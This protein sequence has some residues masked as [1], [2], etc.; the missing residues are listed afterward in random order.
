MAR[1]VRLPIKRAAAAALMLAA[2]LAAPFTAQAALPPDL[3]ERLARDYAR[4]AVAKMTDA[5]AALEGALGE[6][7]A[8]LREALLDIGAQMR[9]VGLAAVARAVFEIDA[10]LP[11]ELA[12]QRVELSAAGAIGEDRAGHGDVPF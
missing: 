8:S 11:E 9:A 3:G 10:C 5:A 6:E 4:P 1:C 7:A 2:P 12:C